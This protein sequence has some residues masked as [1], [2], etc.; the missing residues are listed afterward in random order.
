[1]S[2][3]ARAPGRP[4]RAGWPTRQRRLRRSGGGGFQNTSACRWLV[5]RARSVD[6]LRRALASSHRAA[7]PQRR[8]LMP[9][10]P[11]SRPG[12]LLKRALFN[13]YNYIRLGSTGLFTLATGSWLPAV[14]GA[15]T[16]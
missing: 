14:I 10:E 13:Q 9:D 8:R 5:S 3:R 11:R 7:T 4:R 1:A 6:S 12:S 16:E 15:G 2:R